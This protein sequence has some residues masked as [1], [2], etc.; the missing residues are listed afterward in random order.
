MDL[1]QSY[2]LTKVIPLN[3]ECS[4]VTSFLCKRARLQKRGVARNL[5]R[6]ISVTLGCCGGL[7]RF[8]LPRRMQE[9][10]SSIQDRDPYLE[11]LLMALRAK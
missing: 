5:H 10:I 1:A 8:I 11:S 9:P 3:R 6:L 2:E 7:L 4:D